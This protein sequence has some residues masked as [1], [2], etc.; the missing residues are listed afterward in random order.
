MPAAVRRRDSA[1][2]SG[3]PLANVE[4][5]PCTQMSAVGRRRRG[6][7]I[8]PASTTPS[9][10]RALTSETGTPRFLTRAK[11][12]ALA[13]RIVGDREAQR[14]RR[15]VVLDVVPGTLERR[16][17]GEESEHSGLVGRPLPL[18]GLI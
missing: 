6:S 16:R 14:A 13:A 7:L 8:T 1:R 11:T 5:R 9:R 4:P 2:M 17:A 18:L 15:R 3:W 12:D 10:V